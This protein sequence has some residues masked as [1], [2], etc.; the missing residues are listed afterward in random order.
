MAVL[1][2]E[3]RKNLQDEFDHTKMREK[4]VKE[5]SMFKPGFSVKE[6]FKTNKVMQAKIMGEDIIE[7]D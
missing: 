2:E 4:V 3:S 7:D 6:L 5:K 1:A